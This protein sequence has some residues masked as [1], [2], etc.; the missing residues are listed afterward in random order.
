VQL[1]DGL[2]YGRRQS[3]DTTVVRRLAST[4]EPDEQPPPKFERPAWVSEIL[5]PNFREDPRVEAPQ[6]VE[7]APLTEIPL[8]QLDLTP[9]MPNTGPGAERNGENPGAYQRPIEQG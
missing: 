1:P 2:G 8:D 7:A 4:T 9:A 3:D 6:E 5:P